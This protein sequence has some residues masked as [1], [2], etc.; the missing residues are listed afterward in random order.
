VV[1]FFAD[2]GEELD[3]RG[4]MFH[5]AWLSESS[6]RVPL[7]MHLPGVSARRVEGVAS[8]LDVLPTLAHYL[9]LGAEPAGSASI[10]SADRM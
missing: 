7:V 2:H 5:G 8:L 3:E 10:G 6:T 1:L 9:G 4:G